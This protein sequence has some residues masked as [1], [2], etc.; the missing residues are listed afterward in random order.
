MLILVNTDNVSGES[1]PYLIDSLM[2]RG[3]S[4]VH[5]VSNN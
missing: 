5:A 3:A 4:S 2:D 1:L